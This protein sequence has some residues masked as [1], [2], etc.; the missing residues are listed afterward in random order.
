MLRVII[1]TVFIRIDFILKTELSA[2]SVWM[3]GWVA[4]SPSSGCHLSEPL[5]LP[6]GQF[7]HCPLTLPAWPL[8]G[9]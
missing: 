7:T 3:A 9:F 2:V 5:S 8:L 1:K 4:V 6:G